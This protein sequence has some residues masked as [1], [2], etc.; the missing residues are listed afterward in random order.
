L[1][2]LPAAFTDVKTRALV[3]KAHPCL[4]GWYVRGRG[5][6]IC[7]GCALLIHK[8]TC[9]VSACKRALRGFDS[10]V[11]VLVSK[12]RS[13]VG[14]IHDLAMLAVEKEN[15]LAATNQEIA[16]LRDKELSFYVNHMG[17]IQTISTL[18]AGFAFAALVKMDTTLD[19]NLIKFQATSGS[20]ERI[21]LQT[22]ETLSTPNSRMLDGAEWFAFVMLVRIRFSNPR[23]LVRANAEGVR[24]RI[25][26]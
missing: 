7:A 10:I 25:A 11:C 9:F 21:N 4:Y 8:R 22:G 5:S 24:V 18:V 19:M 12:R 15:L 13:D 3:Y 16:H 6:F 14:W 1:S 23:P 2:Y 26:F 17:S 20:T